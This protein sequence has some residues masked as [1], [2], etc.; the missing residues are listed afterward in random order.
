MFRDYMSYRDTDP[1]IVKFPSQVKSSFASWLLE[2][3]PW[4]RR[5]EP[6]LVGDARRRLFEAAQGVGVDDGD[7]N[8]TNENGV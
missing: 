4:I 1:D 7:I 6:V 2:A 3:H 5:S 8:A